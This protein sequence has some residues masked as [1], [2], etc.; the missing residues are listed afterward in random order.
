MGRK[1]THKHT[2]DRFPNKA[3]NYE[4]GN[5]RWATRKEQARNTKRNVFLTVRGESKTISE[6][7]ELHGVNARLIHSRVFKFGWSHEDAVTV[8]PVVGHKV[9]RRKL[10]DKG[11]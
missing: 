4:P 11:D 9:Q 6:W 3:G 5:C 10:K 7:G 2:I 8:K 1:P